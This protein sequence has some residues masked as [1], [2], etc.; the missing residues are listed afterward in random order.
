MTRPA[1]ILSEIVLDIRRMRFKG[2]RASDIAN[3]LA[4]RGFIDPEVKDHF[5][6]AFGTNIIDPMYLS[7]DAQ[8]QFISA[9]FDE[10]TEPAIAATG[11]SWTQ[12]PPYPDLFRRR[13]RHAFR[14]LASETGNVF[15]VQAAIPN[16]AQFVGM[17]GFKP[18]PL[19]LLDIA[20]TEAPNAGL[21]SADPESKALHDALGSLRPALTYEDYL[22]LLASAG[23][24]VGNRFEGFIVRDSQGTCFYPGYRLL[25]VYRESSGTSAWSGADG[26]RMRWL[27]NRRMGEDL[28]QF[29][30]HD[31]WD[32]RRLLEP[33]NPL[34]GPLAPALFFTPEGNVT[35]CFDAES[36]ERYY[37][38]LKIDWDALY[39]S[40][41]T[42]SEADE[43][44][45]T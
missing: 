5:D 33:D 36:I 18:F 6:A 35:V 27:L 1:E 38:F 26:E 30:P 24:S 8:G 7:R 13:D 22:D 11:D 4:R 28:V 37:R 2:A 9:D 41:M 44:E 10:M 16:A 40:E 42:E 43:E 3:E 39:P 12:A 45:S 23:L 29:G 19:H 32:G 14:K 17:S 31:D 20:R 21:V 15:I 34:R 25:G